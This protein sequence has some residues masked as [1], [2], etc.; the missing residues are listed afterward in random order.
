MRRLLFCLLAS[1]SVCTAAKSQVRVQFVLDSASAKKAANVFI[2][3]N[4]NGWDPADAA[5]RFSGGVLVKQFPA[6]DLVEFKLTAGSWLAVETAA[7]GGD[8][9][10][11]ILK[12]NQDTTVYLSVGAFKDASRPAEKK[13]T[14][15]GNVQLLDTAFYIPQLNRTRLVRLYLPPGYNAGHQRY[16]VLYM[17]DGQNCFDEYTSAFGEWH[18]DEALDHFY[19]S[20][21][22][23]MIVVAVDNGGQLRLNEYDPYPF[24]KVD[25]PEGKQYAAFIAETLKPFVDA[26]FR[27]RPEAKYTHIA[28][29]SMGGVISMY[30]IAAY[31]RVFG[32]AGIFS[33]A[34]WTATPLYDEV[35]KALPAL[36]KHRVFFY[37]GGKES[38]GMIPETIRM[39]DILKAQRQVAAKLVTDADAQH[40]EAAWSKWFPVYL[41]FIFR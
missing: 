39:V 7:N 30:C 34:F 17:A 4:F 5:S 28:G 23:G 33:P 18:A 22:L 16:P 31:P 19:D 9:A 37:A 14:A 41:N 10:N 36:K 6:G 15:S 12:I 2:A 25:Q 26:H 38:K 21:G 24:E 32:N 27:T 8:V 3:G 20:C 40:N 11:R 29:S 1:I 13:H 35:K